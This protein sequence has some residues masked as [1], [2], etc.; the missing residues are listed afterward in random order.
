MTDRDR[1]LTSQYMHECFEYQNGTLI[2]KER[3]I[4]HFADGWRQKIFNSR[5]AGKVAGTP[6]DGYRNVNFRF[7]A[8]SCHRII[9]LMHHGYIPEEIDHINGDK[10][11]NRIENLRACSRSQ[12]MAN[13]R[14]RGNKTGFRGVFENRKRFAAKIQINGKKKYLGNFETPEE[15]H[16]VYCLAAIMIHGEYARNG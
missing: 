1:R 5:Q 8:I 16:E 11:D 2:W 6:V 7:G 9:F 15:A 4:H 3:P 14:P 12:N 10:S 13:T